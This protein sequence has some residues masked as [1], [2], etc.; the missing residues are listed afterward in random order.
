MSM[1][2]LAEEPETAHASAGGA[3][4]SGTLMRLRQFERLHHRLPLTARSA[5]S[6]AAT[7]VRVGPGA[8]AP[9]ASQAVSSGSGGWSAVEGFGSQ[10]IPMIGTATREQATVW[11]QPS[12]GVLGRGP[13]VELGA[14]LT[15]ETR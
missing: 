12:D 4:V 6:G 3:N 7:D 13:H 8:K 1:T 10:L 14:A 15:V 5:A 9:V 11:E 2:L